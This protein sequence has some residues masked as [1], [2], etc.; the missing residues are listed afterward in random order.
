MKKKQ[1]KMAVVEETPVPCVRCG[2]TEL[3]Q[4]AA[5]CSDLCRVT[6]G[7]KS[8]WGY[9]PGDLGLGEDPNYVEFTYCPRCGQMQNDEFKA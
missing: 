4:I 8:E 2:A 5:K 7:G 1:A 6:R 9:V 3:I